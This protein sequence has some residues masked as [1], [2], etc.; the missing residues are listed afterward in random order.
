MSCDLVTDMPPNIIIDSHRTQNNTV[1]MLLHDAT[2]LEGADRLKED[3]EVIAI[4]HKTGRVVYADS[5]ADIKL[6]G[7]NI[8]FRHSLLRKYPE[9]SLHS[10][11]RDAHLYIFKYWV[12]NLIAKNTRLFSIKHDLLPLL[13]E[14]QYRQSC[15][16][17]EGIPGFSL[18]Y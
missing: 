15:R 18:I 7:G 6:R 12:I 16:I 8:G 1:T 11:L 14:C 2:T 9:I 3:G 17:R 13:M 10:T 4:H 5:R